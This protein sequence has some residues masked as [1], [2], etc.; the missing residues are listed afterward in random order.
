MVVKKKQMIQLKGYHLGK[1]KWGT[2]VEI[3]VEF[4]GHGF[5]AK[6]GEETGNEG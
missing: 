4:V 3:R 5:I 2:V 1:V 6:D